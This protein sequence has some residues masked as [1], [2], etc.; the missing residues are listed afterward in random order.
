MTVFLT[1]DESDAQEFID[2]LAAAGVDVIARGLLDFRV[3]LDDAGRRDAARALEAADYVVF[4]SARAVAIALRV[5]PGEPLREK[6][7]AKAPRILCAGAKTAACARRLKLRV[8][9]EITPGGQDAVIRY[10]REIGIG[11][12]TTVVLPRSAAADSRLP[13][14]I[15]QTGAECRDIALYRPDVDGEA[16]DAVERA[17][18]EGAKVYG[19]TSPSSVSAFLEITGASEGRALLSAAERLAIGPTTAAALRELAGGVELVSQR[20]TLADMAHLVLSVY[21]TAGGAP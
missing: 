11:P 20:H 2:P 14:F 9:A 5:A 17:R 3:V 19:F 10:L 13:T 4:T 1:K 21:R 12:G 15:A 16:R 7:D 6:R 8:D 18:R